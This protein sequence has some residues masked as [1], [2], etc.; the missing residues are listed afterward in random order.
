M[1]RLWDVKTGVET[2]RL[3]IDGAVLCIAALPALPDSRINAGDNLGR[4]QWLELVD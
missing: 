2:A 1:I 3:Q 4:L